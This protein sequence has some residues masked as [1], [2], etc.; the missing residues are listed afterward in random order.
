MGTLP[1][2]FV[3]AF[4]VLDGS[5]FKLD[6]YRV[7]LAGSVMFL[8]TVLMGATFPLVSRVYL[9]RDT[10]GA[11]L[12][13]LYAAN[14]VGAILGSFVTG[15]VLVPFLGRQASVLVAC[16]VNLAA[17]LLLLPAV[18]WREAGPAL[19]LAM[20]GL[21]VAAIPAFVW[22]QRPWDARVLA[23]GAY[24]YA[25]TYARAPSIRDAL[26]GDHLVYYDEGAEGTVSVW[27][28]EYQT[29]LRINGKVDASSHGDRVTQKLLAH[30]P[31]LYH[32]DPMAG[33]LVIGLGS[34]VSAG[35]LL[36]YPID[37]VETVELMPGMV[38]AAHR[39]DAYNRRP[40]DDPRHHLIVGDGRNHLRLTDRRYDVI[41]S[42]PSNPWIAGIGSLF[43]REFFR[44]AC[45]RLAPGGVL[46]QWV[47]IYD[48]NPDD[49]RAIF[50][51]VTEV[52]PHVH[53][54]MASP[55]DLILIAS[56]D[57]LELDPDA[58]TRALDGVPG[59]DLASVEILPVEQLL[60][61]FITDETGLAA[62]AG[63]AARVTDDNLYLETAVPR[64]M[65]DGSPR[66]RLSALEAL[67]RPASRLLAG[68]GTAGLD[69]QV[70]PYRT[71]RMLAYAA[72][73]EG[74]L[75]PGETEAQAVA[76]AHRIAPRELLARKLYGAQRLRDGIRNL[77]NGDP[78][79][80]A[81]ILGA[82][83]ADGLRDQQA[84]AC[85]Y[86]GSLALEAGDLE[87]ANRR[88]LRCLSLEPRYPEAY[89]YLGDIA[90]KAGRLDEG[91][92]LLAKAT[93]LVPTHTAAWVRR[94]RIHALRG[95]WTEAQ[96]CL[97]PARRGDPQS[98]ELAMVEGAVAIETG[99]PKRAVERFQTV[100]AAEPRKAE[101]V[102]NLAVA[103][104]G[105]D[106]F[107]EAAT[108]WKRYLE[109]R[110]GNAEAQQSLAWL[111]ATRLDAPG[112][113]ET[114]ARAS[115]GVR[116]SAGGFDALAESLYRQGKQREAVEAAKRALSLEDRPYYREQLARFQ[117][118]ADR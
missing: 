84:T 99:R 66:V 116:P 107:A 88:W 82:V 52:F 15:F 25:E 68:R 117:G 1:Q 33:G 106:D 4:P 62:Y 40:L 71:A 80:A 77:Q 93:D 53:A 32:R 10:V 24:V 19:R 113:A 65:V 55:G 83:A 90:V 70:D 81:A 29:T 43:T 16:G 2:R 67:Q 91:Q 27:Q 75:P 8:P 109:L 114:L 38:E 103:Y 5:W 12:G 51:T 58:L 20:A 26:A 97:E 78:Q 89:V 48:F 35:A 11:S 57:P 64:H 30:L 110:P 47:Q 22:G 49:L 86:L 9:G 85:L 79:T 59:E 17:V 56:E 23:S 50:A 112:E 74:S 36:A 94:A 42:E 6:L 37:R 45:D 3:D 61:C 108:T 41:V 92:D 46:S 18:R 69:A 54:W 95:E 28:R 101:A 21:L 115:M 63:N 7:L 96:A 111:L 60:S 118:G 105:V 104:E 98:L 31:A 13:S 34:G 102:Y 44:L 100:L 73:Y 76:A 72:H 14:T 87:D 39:F